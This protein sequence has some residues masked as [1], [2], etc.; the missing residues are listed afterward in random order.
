MSSR[1]SVK[2]IESPVPLPVPSANTTI[3]SPVKI[4][5][6]LV[7]EALIPPLTQPVD[8]AYGIAWRTVTVVG[9]EPTESET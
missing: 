1:L 2:L 4:G 8:G 5:V 7:N 6:A 3:I 9:V